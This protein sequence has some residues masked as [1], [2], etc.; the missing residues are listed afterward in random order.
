MIDSRLPVVLCGISCMHEPILQA[1]RAV[2]V[3]LFTARVLYRV[4][5]RVLEAEMTMGHIL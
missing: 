5:Y 2:R 4:C 1:A 3:K